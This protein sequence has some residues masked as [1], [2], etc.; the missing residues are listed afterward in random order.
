MHTR[1][2]VDVLGLGIFNP[3]GRYAIRGWRCS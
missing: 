3:E 1:V 2:D